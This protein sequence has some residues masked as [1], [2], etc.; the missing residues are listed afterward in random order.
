[1]TEEARDNLG[2]SP[3]LIKIYKNLIN[4]YSGRRKFNK[5]EGGYKYQ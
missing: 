1:M 2:I 4:K 3:K 5:E